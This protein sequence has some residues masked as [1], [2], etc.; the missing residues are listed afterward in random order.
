MI[1]SGAIVGQTASTVT[2]S[3]GSRPAPHKSQTNDRLTPVSDPNADP[4]RR[5]RTSRHRGSWSSLSTLT[6]PCLPLVI[7]R[8]PASRGA[9][10]RAL[11][12]ETLITQRAA[13]RPVQQ[14]VQQPTAPIATSAS[15]SRTP[16]LACDRTRPSRQPKTTQTVRRLNGRPM[17]RQLPGSCLCRY[18]TFLTGSRGLG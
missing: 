6:A 12:L 14:R 11:H 15:R 17:R 13:T 10:R 16:H 9:R 1:V 2:V 4:S 5:C 18:A 7:G 3:P 8:S